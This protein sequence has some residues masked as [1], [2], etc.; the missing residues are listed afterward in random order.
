M[1][2]IAEHGMMTIQLAM[3]L[4]VID[5][6]QRSKS[7]SPGRCGCSFKSVTFERMVAG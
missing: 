2:F 5:A 7:L 3:T 1:A 6:P 4:E